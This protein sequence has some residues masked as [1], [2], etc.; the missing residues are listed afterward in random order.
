MN[1]KEYIDKLANQLKDLDNKII[2]MEDGAEKVASNLKSEYQNQVS[3][4][5]RKK[6]DVKVKL[7]ELNNSNQ[8]AFSVLKEGVTSSFNELKDAIDGAVKKFK[9][10]VN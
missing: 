9:N 4:L 5:N 1:R 7:K 6:D 8:E 2:K 10:N 3:V